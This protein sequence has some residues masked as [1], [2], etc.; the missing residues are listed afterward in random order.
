METPYLARRYAELTAGS[1]QQFR[2]A[3]FSP[4]LSTDFSHDNQVDKIHESPRCSTYQADELSPV[5]PIHDF[6]DFGRVLDPPTVQLVD[7]ADDE[8]QLSKSDYDSILEGSKVDLDLC[9]SKF[10]SP[11]P[12]SPEKVSYPVISVAMENRPSPV[13]PLKSSPLNDYP[14]FAHPARLKS[15]SPLLPAIDEVVEP[16]DEQL[17]HH[18]LQA[19]SLRHC[20]ATCAQSQMEGA[21]LWQ[22]WARTERCMSPPCPGEMLEV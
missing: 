19:L 14:S 1:P 2:M 12:I 4:L 8:Y 22:P 6:E 20:A 11:L 16:S 7:L 18:D 9:T 5:Q 15:W 10:T 3:F 17:N 13:V 21:W